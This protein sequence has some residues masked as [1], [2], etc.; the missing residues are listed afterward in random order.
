MNIL[1][2]TEKWCD[3]SPDRGLTNNFHN[4][5][6]SFEQSRPEDTINTL[7]LDECS[8]VYGRSIDSILLS[9]CSQNK[10]DVVI[11]SLLGNSP[12]NPSI[13]TINSLK[14]VG[15]KTVFMWPDT[16]EWAL[17]QIFS[18][19]G[20][21]DLSVS[22]DNAYSDRHN[23]IKY[24]ANHRNMW[25]P[26]DSSMFSFQYQNMKNI[27]VSFVGSI[28]ADR[29]MFLALSSKDI[30]IYGGQRGKRLSSYQYADVIR[31]SKIS[32]N[33]P[34]SPCNTFYQ[35][36]G[37]VYEI[38]SCG[39]MLLEMKNDTTPKLF[40]PGIDYVEFDSVSN[41]DEAI[42]YYLNNEYEREKIAISGSIKYVNMY[43]SK[44]FW[45]T[46]INEIH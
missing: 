12:L 19:D 23:S 22:W 10:T 45:D 9:Y 20:I 29:A 21:A 17:N 33:F 38:F 35:I 16:S 27:D 1:F 37:R 13:E 15:I 5:F 6:N 26:Q 18:L 30:S 2:C 14:A 24:P 7:H 42:E 43:S 46:I 8:L 32:L 3:A 31:N 11:F 39:S 36:K 41:M 28:Y 4:L 40:R 34:L 25:V 44:I